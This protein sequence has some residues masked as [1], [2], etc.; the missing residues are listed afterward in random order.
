MDGAD[1]FAANVAGVLEGIAQ[2]T[3]RG[4]AGDELDALD[5]AVDDNV[6]DARVFALCVFADQDRV[7]VVV[8]RLVAGNGAAGAHVGE[9]VEGA[10]QRQVERDVALAN[11]RGE[12]ALEGDEV[13][14]DAADGLVG[15]DRLAVLVEPRRHVDRLPLDGHVG[16]RVDVLDR[17]RNLGPDAVALDERDAVLAVVALCAV[18]LGHLGGVGARLAGCQCRS[19]AA[20][21]QQQQ[22]TCESAAG[23]HTE[24]V[25]VAWRRHCRAGADRER[26]ASMVTVR[27]SCGYPIELHALLQQEIG[28]G[29]GRRCRGGAGAELPD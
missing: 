17:L 13:L 4:V 26:A 23:A 19:C 5:D 12:G 7:D 21:A 15:D 29:G 6:L 25:R 2:D 14:G 16:G 28:A 8:G 27:K 24:R 11:G 10:A 1:L 22:L 18:E 3:L 20:V 9:E